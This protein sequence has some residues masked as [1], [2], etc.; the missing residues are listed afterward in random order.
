[1]GEMRRIVTRKREKYFRVWE[2]F[3]KKKE[4]VRKRKNTPT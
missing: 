1:M 3:L 2:G 4:V